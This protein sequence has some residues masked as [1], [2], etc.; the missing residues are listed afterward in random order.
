MED[1]LEN[2]AD[3]ESEIDEEGKNL[4]QQRIDGDLPA[5]QPEE[6]EPDESEA[7]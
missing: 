1:E 5:P 6:F 2:L 7:E 3:L 4:T